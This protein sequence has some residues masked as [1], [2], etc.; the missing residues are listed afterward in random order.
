MIVAHGVLTVGLGLVIRPAPAD[1]WIYAALGLLVGGLSVATARSSFAGG[2]LLPVLAAALVSAIAF[3]TH[4]GNDAASLRL[5]IPPLVTFLGTM[6]VRVVR[7]ATSSSRPR[8][9]IA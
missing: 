3:L 5:T 9:V 7:I 2:Y 4:G 8:A 1:L 6:I